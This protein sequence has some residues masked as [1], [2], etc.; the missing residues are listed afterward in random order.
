MS[1][2]LPSEESRTS[3]GASSGPSETWCSFTPF[4]V[5]RRGGMRTVRFRQSGV[6]LRRVYGERRDLDLHVREQ[7]Q[8][9]EQ[10]VQL[11]AGLDV[12]A[13]VV[14]VLPDHPPELGPLAG[15][16]DLVRACLLP[17]AEVVG[18]VLGH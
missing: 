7:R 10:L 5:P 3:G 4:T 8:A 18:D 2:V 1:T 13:A 9:R 12:E 6:E 11:V 16:L 15:A 14:R 17:G